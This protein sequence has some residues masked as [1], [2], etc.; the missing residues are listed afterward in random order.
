MKKAFKVLVC[1][2]TLICLLSPLTSFADGTYMSTERFDSNITVLED[3]SFLVSETI[4]VNFKFERHGIYRYIPYRTTII[5]DVNGKE[6][7][8]NVRIRVQDIYVEGENFETYKENGNDV[9]VIGDEDETVKGLKTYKINYKIRIPDDEIKDYDY[10]Y[11][12]FLPHGWETSIKNAK[13]SFTFPRKTDLSQAYI[14]SG[15]LGEAQTDDFTIS[16]N[17]QTLIAELK[18]PLK[19]GDGATFYTELPNEYFN[20][21][22]QNDL[23][24]FLMVLAIG[25]AFT[26]VIVLK[27]VFGRKKEIVPILNFYPP[28]D[29]TSAD[30]GYILDGVT[31]SKDAISLIIYWADKGLI[32]IVEE[33]KETLR[34]VKLKELY[35]DANPYERLMFSALFKD[36][37]SVTTKDLKEK[38]YQT[39]A[40]TKELIAKHNSTKKNKTFKTSS[41]VASV[42][43]GIL[44]VV[45]MF[46]IL[47]FGYNI[48][49]VTEGVIVGAIFYA[50]LLGAAIVF[51]TYAVYKT[52]AEKKGINF[53]KKLISW[54]IIVLIV[55]GAALIGGVVLGY[56]KIS[57]AAAV[58]TLACIFMSTR[59]RVY[60][61][62][63][64]RKIEQILGFKEFIKTAE[65]DR[66][67]MLVLSNP[68]Y[69]YNVLPYAYVMGL[70]DV[71]S[72]KFESIAVPAPNWYSGRYNSTMFN[73]YLFMNAFDNN[74]N[75]IKT[76]MV[77]IPAKSSSSGGGF[78]GGG[79]SGGG[80]SGGGGGSW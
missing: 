74:M 6:V 52:N 77:S 25:A 56:D 21:E 20:G 54:I 33:D 38:F 73:T 28:D 18:A 19:K 79:F 69:F 30:I 64:Y 60:T 49:I 9:I 57:L 46:A 59:M 24:T 76:N 41:I 39:I 53:A 45:P 70:S 62:S 44:S 13:V 7:E 2:A 15:S 40:Q 27:I 65:L 32:S 72:K 8:K 75:T 68:E 71:W 78:S 80:F 4:T 55:L 5:N 48:K 58:I 17:G 23:L 3:N 63:G 11:F 22:E 35:S 51:L 47:L 61:D 67:N 1:V 36:R 34:I 42:F 14:L 12:N 50:I 37:S 66:L 10:V 31:D 29:M 16:E 26:I 43:A